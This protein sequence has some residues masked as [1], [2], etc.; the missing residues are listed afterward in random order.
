MMLR[1]MRIST[2]DLDK[3][4]AADGLVTAS[5]TVQVWRVREEADGTII[6][7]LV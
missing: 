6:S 4:F 3:A 7:V 2:L 1:K 5:R